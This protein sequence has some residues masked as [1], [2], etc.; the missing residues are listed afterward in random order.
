MNA[1]IEKAKYP[2]NY[3][4]EIAFADGKISQVDF[5]PF[6]TSDIP[7]YLKV[8]QQKELFKKFHITHGNVVWGEDWDL[9]FPSEQLY[10]GKITLRQSSVSL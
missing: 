3:I 6:L 4:L 5:E 10:E 1:V 2:K 9:I 8:C 7:K